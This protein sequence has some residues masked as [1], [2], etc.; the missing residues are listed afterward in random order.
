L[1]FFG[2]NITRQ[3]SAV[4]ATDVSPLAERGGWF[5]LI[6]EPFT[7]AWQRNQEI[8]RESILAYNAVFACV[9]LIASDIAK[10]RVYLVEQDKDGI[11]AEVNVAAFSP[12]LAKPNSIQNRIK[13]YE[14]W[15]VSKLLNGNT[16]VLKVRDQRNVVTALY[17]LDPWR[18]RP[19][20]T[21]T[22]DVYYRLAVD[23]FAGIE[24]ETIVPAS[25]IIHDT[26]IC[27]YHPLCGVSPLM[28]CGLAASQGLSIQQNSTAFFAN[29]SQPSGILTAPG[30]IADADAARLKAHWEEKYTGINAGKI[31][32]VGSGL[33]YASMTMKAVDAQLLEQLKWSA[34]TVCSVFHVPPYMIGAAP[35]PAYNNIEALGQ[36]YYSQCLQSLFESI[37]L[38]LDE[39]LGLSD[40]Q[41][42]TYGT[43]FELDN[44]LRMDTA[45][46][47]KT[48]GEGIGSGLLAPDEG[49]KKLNL[50]SVPGGNTPY[51]QQQNFSLAA[52]ARR[53][54]SDDPFALAPKR[55]QNTPTPAEQAAAEEAAAAG[56]SSQPQ[57]IAAAKVLAAWKL[58]S[59][60][61]DFADAA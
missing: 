39:G 48:Y 10:C 1:R 9:T 2:L 58:R 32:V 61:S 23:H 18:V 26:M 14:H 21:P 59:L 53:D 49:R 27:L 54:S 34:E 51:L 3:K 11:W 50:K 60:L 24:E 55:D 43:E 33:T 52:L 13:F 36:Q 5:P 15:I 8:R 12:V 57:D 20:I 6:R 19:L 22:G 41:Q 38:C 37:E 16:Y 7:G 31:A 30:N 44:L 29:G 40:H 17:V 42:H 35:A 25:E 47:Y 4:Q 46:Q 45:T 28:A 56:K